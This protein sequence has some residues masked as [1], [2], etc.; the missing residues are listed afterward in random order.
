MTVAPTQPTFLYPRLKI[1]LKDRHFDTL[2][3]MEAETQVVLNTLT[4]EDFQDA[5]KIWQ[6]R[7]ERFIGGQQAQ[8]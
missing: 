3:V 7:W 2:E 1:K 4:E 5:F 6:E 8:S